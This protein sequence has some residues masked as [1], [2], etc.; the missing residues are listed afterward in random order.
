MNWAAD[1]NVDHQII[2]VLR[3]LGHT[4]WSVAEQ[5]SGLADEDV[6][7]EA[8]TR[9]AVLLTSDKD[10]GELVFRQK[11]ASF[12]VVLIRLAGLPVDVRAARVAEAI[13]SV[14]SD[15]AGNFTVIDRTGIR[16]R[17]A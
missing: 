9:R 12:G 10:F 7:G 17:R 11:R 2:G 15:V 1:E 13:K 3:A 8:L 5:D 14:L 4:V 6:L 16:I